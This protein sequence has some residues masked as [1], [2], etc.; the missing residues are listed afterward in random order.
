ME[1]VSLWNSGARGGRPLRAVWL[2]NTSGLTLDGGSFSVVEG[3]AFAGEGLMEPLEPGERRLLSYAADLAVLVSARQ[4]ET[5]GR[6]VRV[7][8]H[9]GV[10]TQQSEERASWTYTLRN[11]DAAPR[12]VVI[13]HPIRPGWKLAPGVTPAETSPA[14][15]RFRVTVDPRKETTLDVNEIRL[16]ESTVAVSALSNRPARRS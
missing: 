9:G 14:A 8:A 16:G 11:E 1:K 6:L 7:R 13:E 3:D 4:G 10:I 15:Y 2:T 5:R 12:V